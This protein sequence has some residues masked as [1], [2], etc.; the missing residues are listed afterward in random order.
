MSIRRLANAAAAIP[1][2][3]SLGCAAQMSQAGGDLISAQFPAQRAPVSRNI[4][5]VV[6]NENGVVSYGTSIADVFVKNRLELD[7]GH[8]VTRMRDNAPADSLLMAANAA[9]LVIIA[10]SV[11]SGALNTKIVSTP[12]PI[13]SYEAFLQDEFGL[14]NPQGRPVDPGPPADNADFG[15]IEDQTHI[16]IVN[17]SHPMAAGLSGLVQVYRFPREMNWGKALAPSAEVVATLPDYPDAAIIYLIRKGAPLYNGTP[18]PGLR[19]QYFTEND[20]QTGTVNLMT[21]PGLRLFDAAIN[22]ALT[23]DPAR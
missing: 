19:V 10:E 20:N 11:T 16:N 6:G 13:F 18:A 9:D 23:T 5:M 4:L 2:F 22:Y 15:A 12:T 21:G 14:V 1:L 17:P 8:T 7:M 3:M